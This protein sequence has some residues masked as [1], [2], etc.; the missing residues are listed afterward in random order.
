[1]DA[2]ILVV[3]SHN[4]RRAAAV[5]GMMGACATMTETGLA[6][7]AQLAEQRF[8]NR[9][10]PRTSASKHGAERR[11]FPPIFP[12]LMTRF[13]GQRLHAAAQLLDIDP[14]RLERTAER[15]RPF[16]VLDEVRDVQ[17]GLLGKGILHRE[18]YRTYL[19]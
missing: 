1:M 17:Q 3:S 12:L 15:G 6:T 11:I 19:G 8:C 16:G 4:G 5:I 2:D 10:T 18:R 14:R 9:P 7:V 13:A